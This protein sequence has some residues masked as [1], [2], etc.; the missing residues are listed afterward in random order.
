M[1]REID[2]MCMKFQICFKQKLPEYKDFTFRSSSSKI[3]SATAK[4]IKFPMLASEN[5][6]D[7]I[8]MSIRT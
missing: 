6:F 2:F 1:K 4:F 7:A 5:I 8:D 3:I